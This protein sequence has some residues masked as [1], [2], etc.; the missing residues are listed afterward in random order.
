MQKSAD[1]LFVLAVQSSAN[2]WSGGTNRPKWSRSSLLRF[3]RVGVRRNI[4]I[5]TAFHL[6]NRRSK[7]NQTTR[8]TYELKTVPVRSLLLARSIRAQADITAVQ[9]RT[10]NSDIQFQTCCSAF[11]LFQSLIFICKHLGFYFKPKF[12]AA[13]VDS[14]VVAQW[15]LIC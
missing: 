10:V 14:V 1:V 3:A 15:K 11:C 9:T 2:L 6:C 5:S 12:R 8:Y 4:E 7:I 13:S